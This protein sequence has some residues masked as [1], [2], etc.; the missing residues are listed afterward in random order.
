MYFVTNFINANVYWNAIFLSS[1]ASFSLSI[2]I[3]QIM[4]Y[5]VL[6]IRLD[7]YVSHRALKGDKID[8]S[9]LEK[10]SFRERIATWGFSILIFA[11]PLACILMLSINYEDF[12]GNVI[13]VWEKYELF[14]MFNF[15]AIAIALCIT[16]FLSLSHM[17]KVFGNESIKEE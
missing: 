13:K 8:D 1:P 17:R 2:G 9:E 14:Y 6:Y 11:Y 3:C 16:T 15:I 7:S 10:A 12:D 5:V 4:N